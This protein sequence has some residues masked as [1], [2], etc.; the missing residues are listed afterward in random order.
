M[1]EIIP[2]VMHS[3]KENIRLII[4]QS[5]VLKV[6][7]AVRFYACSLILATS[8]MYTN[9]PSVELGPIMLM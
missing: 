4:S 7:I 6:S 1:I 8:S 3:N 5:K 9:S 2:E